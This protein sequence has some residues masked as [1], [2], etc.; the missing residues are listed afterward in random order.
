MATIELSQ[1]AH[2]YN[3]EA[4]EPI[5]ALKELDMTWN[6]GGTY[7][8]LGPSGCGKTTMLNIISGLIHPSRGQVLFDGQ[9]F[10]L[11]PTPKRNIAQVFQFPVIYTLMTVRENLA[12][13]LA[14]RRV[15]KAERERRVQEV[16]E[17][18]NLSAKLDKPAR[19]LDADEKQL[20][21]LGRGLVRND[22]TALL[23]DEPLTVIDPQLKFEIRRKLKTINERYGLTM[24]YVTHDQNEAMTFADTIVVMNHGEV[25]QVGTPEDLHNKPQT[26]YVGY[27]IGSPAM[28]FIKCT[29]GDGCLQTG[30]GPISVPPGLEIPA[31]TSELQVGIR[32][33]YPKL[34]RTPG[35][36]SIK[37]RVRLVQ[38]FGTYR[39][40]TLAVGEELLRL[41][42]TQ[43]V[44]IPSDEA[45][46][47]FPPEWVCLYADDVLVGGPC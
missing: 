9:D 33:R 16:A 15:P 31:G 46:V 5:W 44:E 28:N 37:G 25:I 1:I 23:M 40:V 29:L 12:F 2:S 6:D 34:V 18:L 14:C 10:T 13:P 30:G 3:H 45:W 22:V 32:P 21:S 7:A 24:V 8:L 11:R 26:T 38:E 43:E 47:D 42:L 39:V 36:H 4:E 17:L 19:R 41:K 35:E 27:F 20:I